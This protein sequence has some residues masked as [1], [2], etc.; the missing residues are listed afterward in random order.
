MH[1]DDTKIKLGNTKRN[2]II[3]VLQKTYLRMHKP[4]L[5]L[6]KK[7]FQCVSII[8]YYYHYYYHHLPSVVIMKQTET[9]PLKKHNI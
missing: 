4:H 9:F 6:G 3:K 7:R 1:I 5:R 2:K 8:Y